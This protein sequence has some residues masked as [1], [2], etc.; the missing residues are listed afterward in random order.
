[1]RLLLALFFFATT[2]HAQTTRA[3]IVSG[4]T[5]DPALS[6]QMRRDETLLRDAIVKRFGGNAVLLAENSTPRSDRSAIQNALTQ[7]ARESGADDRIIIVLLGNAST[8]G[9][10]ARFNI[11]GPDVT[12]RELATWL[13]P[14]NGRDLAVVIA[15]SAS[16]AFRSALTA[17]GRIVVTAT[18]SAVENESV[19]FPHYFVK[20]FSEDVADTDKDG[21]L[22]L[23]EAFEF[24]RR[25]VAR[26]YQQENRLATEHAMLDDSVR[27]RTFVLR[28]GSAAPANDA[29]KSLYAQRAALDRQ[30][31]EL[32]ARKA[33]MKPDEYDATLEKLLLQ[34]AQVGQSIRA[35]GGQ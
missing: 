28:T 30:V 2:A 4:I 35:A 19:T 20:A 17:P 25:E 13:A 14:F 3:L 33:Q 22:S 21:G 12:A 27:A 7:L 26:G 29:L 6:A 34:L 18:R 32:K 10:E 24:A 23:A 9:E 1:M 31:A 8:D 11:P 16:G 5:G 15:T